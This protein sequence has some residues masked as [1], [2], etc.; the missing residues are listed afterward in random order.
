[1][2]KQYEGQKIFDALYDIENIKSKLR[3]NYPDF[4]FVS[5]KGD[6]SEAFCI[7]SYDLT[8]APTGKS[9]FDATTKDGKTVSIKFLWEINKYRAIALSGGSN[10]KEYAYKDADLLLVL[11]RDEYT[12]K[13]STIFNGPLEFLEPYIKGG[14]VHPRIEV[15]NL[16]KI[17]PFVPKEQRLKA[18][19]KPLPD[20][21]PLYYPK[22]LNQLFD[23]PSGY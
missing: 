17:Y 4:T 8:K 11:G 10:R 1:M 9:G 16:K 20:A 22:D 15:R 18:V 6:I 21:T 7:E 13:I 14:P 5:E 19:N 3:S 23:I 2:K 12:G